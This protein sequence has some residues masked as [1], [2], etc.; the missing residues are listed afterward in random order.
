[1]KIPRRTLGRLVLLTAALATTLAAGHAQAQT[2]LDG[3]MKAKLIK[4]AVP[5]DFPPMASSASTSSPRAWMWT[6]P[7][8]S[9]AS[10]G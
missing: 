8:S 6:R 7:T 4:I 10:S 9:P 2:A 3:V 1:M 5:T